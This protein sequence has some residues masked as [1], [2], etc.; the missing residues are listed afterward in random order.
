MEANDGY[1]LGP[2]GLWPELYAQLLS[3]RW[4]QMVGTDDP[5]DFGVPVPRM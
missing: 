1:S 3:A 4:A 2:Y 5:C